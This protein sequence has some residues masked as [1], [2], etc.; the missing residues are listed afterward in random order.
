VLKVREEQLLTLSL[1]WAMTND[2]RTLVSL[3]WRGVE[4]KQEIPASLGD[5]TIA[6]R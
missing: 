1:G 3:D 6:G 2:D 5:E 4:P